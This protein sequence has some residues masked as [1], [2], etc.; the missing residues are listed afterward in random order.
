MSVATFLGL[1][2]AL[3]GPALLFMPTHRFLGDP[4]R[5]STRVLELLFLWML[6]ALVLVIVI[7]WEAQPISSIGL[8]LRWESII[9]G[10]LLAVV[11]I[12]LVAPVLYW[13]VN[14]IGTSGFEEGLA[15]LS[16][17]PIWFL[18]FAAI[19]GGVVEELLYRGYAI[20]RLAT[21][22]GSYGWA[23]LIS[24][25]VF[26]MVHL[27]MWGWGPVATF[28]VSGG[29]IALFYIWTQD[30][31][32]CMIGHAVTDAVGFITAH[33]AAHTTRNL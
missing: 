29:L 31:V 4:E 14:R 16:H 30:L 13:M 8:A 6:A 33:R 26:A 18:L 19:T 20:E 21:L 27:P 17:M 9:L 22:T 25:T 3:F 12:R 28:F 2:I 5:F 24:T 7:G 11:F 32:A 23:S 10:L 1:C 15:K